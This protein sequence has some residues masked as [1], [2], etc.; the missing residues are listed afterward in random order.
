MPLGASRLSF[1]ALSQTAGVAPPAAAFNADG[2][3]IAAGGYLEANGSHT[4]NM[5]STSRAGTFSF[6]FKDINNATRTDRTRI[7]T[8]HDTNDYYL[9]GPQLWLETNNTLTVYGYRG[10]NNGWVMQLA[11]ANAVTDSNWHHCAITYDRATA[12]SNAQVYID[13]VSKTIGFTRYNNDEDGW[14]YRGHTRIG[15]YGSANSGDVGMAI[16]QFWYDDTY[17]DIGANLDKFYDSTNSGAVDMGNDGTSSGLDAPAIYHYG[18]T[19]TFYTNNGRTSG[20]NIAYTLTANGTIT[21]TVT[22]PPP[23]SAISVTA[24]G[25]AQVDTAQSKFGGAS[26]VFDGAGDYLDAAGPNL[27][28][29]EWTIEMF[30]RFDSVAG[31]RVLYDDRESA[32]TSSGTILLYTN[33]STLYFNSQQ[34]NKISGA[35]LGTNTWYHIAVVRDSSSDVRMYLDGTQ[36][37]SSYNDTNNFAQPDGNGWFGMNHQSPN[38]HMFDGY[39]DEIRFSNTARYTSNFTPSAT[40]FVNDSDTLMLLHC[41]GTDGSTTFTDDTGTGRSPVGISAN[42][43]AQLDTAQSKFGGASAYV[44]G[45]GDYLQINDTPTFGADDFTIEFWWRPT[46]KVDTYPAM[47]VNM[48]GYN[49]GA[50]H[51]CDRHNAYSTKFSAF[52]YHSS[53]SLVSSTTVSNNTWYHIALCRDGSTIRLFINGTAEASSSISGDIGD[54]AR[55]FHWLG[56]NSGYYVNGHMDEVRVSD[57][58]R[59]TTNFT[60]TASAFTNDANTLY[61]L[62]MDGADGSTDFEDDNS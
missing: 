15:S 26:A 24:N 55:T 31:V 49:T 42:G 44:D 41:D 13:G 56:R 7:F 2:V 29:G 57:T 32:N 5:S 50:I 47:W 19:S 12:Q 14:N 23:R 53:I 43:N 39:L 37:G 28:S 30:A 11:I 45:S 38:N 54:S 34:V 6:W 27:G 36:I 1:L 59:Y 18:N 16:A 61:L 17:I 9:S 60:P 8:G 46:S 35:T 20:N 4:N 62:H 21:D 22:G 52:L 58:A 40:P 3:E 25:N 51:I 10:I 33:G 48:D